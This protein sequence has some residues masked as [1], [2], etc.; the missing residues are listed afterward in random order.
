[1]MCIC[2]IVRNKIILQI[3]V[4]ISITK[5]AFSIRKKCIIKELICPIA[6]LSEKLDLMDKYLRS[7]KRNIFETTDEICCG[8]Y[9]FFCENKSLH[10]LQL[11][12]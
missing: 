12:F 2:Y 10:F 8:N 5:G 9:N 11:N 1:M 4:D 7:R 3:S 6:S